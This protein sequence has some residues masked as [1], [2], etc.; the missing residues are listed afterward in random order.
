MDHNFLVI[1]YSAVLVASCFM[2]F[3]LSREAIREGCLA[4]WRGLSRNPYFLLTSGLSFLSVGQIGLFSLRFNDGLHGV[5]LGGR[6]PIEITVSMVMI[7]LAT[8]SFLW[9]GTLRGKR[10]TWRLFVAATLLDVGGMA[11][12]LFL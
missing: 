3:T 2:L 10:K 1:I 7:W 12:W 9:V 11:I 8:V 4:E 6:S 5:R